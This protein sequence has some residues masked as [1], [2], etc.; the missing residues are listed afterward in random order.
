MI[1]TGRFSGFL[2]KI[3]FSLFLKAFILLG[4]TA[5]S[6]PSVASREALK[7]F[8]AMLLGFFCFLSGLGLIVVGAACARQTTIMQRW[9]PVQAQVVASEVSAAHRLAKGYIVELDYTYSLGGSQFHARRPVPGFAAN[10]EAALKTQQIYAPGATVDIYVNPQ[11]PSQSGIADPESLNQGVLFSVSG[12]F[13]LF[14]SF[15]LL[16]LVFRRARR[17]NSANTDQV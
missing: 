2:P 11:D 16:R 7:T 14:F 13:L 8:A 15:F 10:Q 3:D 12:S 17:I 9:S 1:G 4:M 5:S 6:S